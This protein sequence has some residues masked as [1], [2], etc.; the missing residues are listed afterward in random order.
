VKGE[1]LHVLR[2][3]RGLRGTREKISENELLEKELLSLGLVLELGLLGNE[4]VG[5][6][7]KQEKDA[8][9]SDWTNKAKKERNV[10]V[11]ASII[12][13]NAGTHSLESYF[14]SDSDFGVLFNLDSFKEHLPF[15][16]PGGR[17]E[18]D[19]KK[20][21]THTFR[22]KADPFSDDGFWK[23]I[24]DYGLEP[25]DLRKPLHELGVLGESVEIATFLE[26]IKKNKQAMIDR[27]IPEKVVDGM[28]KRAE[29][30]S[31]EKALGN[32]ES[33]NGFMITRRV[34]PRHFDGIYLTLERYGQ[35]WDINE[36]KK[37]FKESKP[38]VKKRV[39][40]AV[41]MMQ[42]V[43]E[44]TGKNRYLPIYDLYGNLLWP[45]EMNY[46]EVKQ[47]VAEREEEQKRSRKK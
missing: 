3:S 12:G 13:R 37:C 34:A 7:S 41:E 27:G 47:F 5:E 30:E 25:R 11:Y 14:N 22:A 40:G 28:I 21:K 20:A 46:E 38:L 45:K 9:V 26:K 4:K 29:E 42:Q 33:D 10:V 24:A 15:R 31:Y 1:A 17:N 2:N 16:E 39:K 6:P 8:L 32:P 36:R 23:F 43:S 35:H 18:P 44:K 19:L